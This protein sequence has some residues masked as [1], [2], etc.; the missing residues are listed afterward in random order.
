MSSIDIPSTPAGVATAPVVPQSAAPVQAADVPE[1]KGSSPAGTEAASDSWPISVTDL[2]ALLVQVPNGPEPGEEVSQKAIEGDPDELPAQPSDEDPAPTPPVAA[3]PQP[4]PNPQAPEPGEE[5]GED[6]PKRI[7]VES[8]SEDERLALQIKKAK[9]I[10]LE[11][12]LQ[13]VK[14][15]NPPKAETPPAP[16]ENPFAGIPESVPHSVA[17]IDL[18]LESIDSEQD[19]LEIQIEAR[20]EAF[21][22]ATELKAQR[23]QLRAR[24]KE[25]N[26]AR[27]AVQQAEQSA[28]RAGE[29]REIQTL[30]RAYQDDG[31]QD[32][33]SPLRQA[34]EAV[35]LRWESLGDPRLQAP[36]FLTQLAEA[37][38]VEM[39]RLPHKYAA[40]PPSPAAPSAPAAAS[41]Q[42][43]KIQ[44]LLPASG[45]STTSPPGP[46]P[47][48]DP[49]RLT[50][51]ELSEL[52]GGDLALV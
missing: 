50:R 21:E 12:A 4:T 10:S 8:F 19:A 47:G 41:P 16:L 37:G 3:E 35:R 33:Q 28:A 24:Q 6:L 45:R 29:D 31:I 13:L 32:A 7:R 1:S 15:A 23:Q 49:S 34:M 26:K 2:E 27:F 40:S 48:F 20:L 14:Q 51:H 30:H 9:G 42:T 52:L 25:L 22:D 11:E 36:N 43:P 44:P 38:C 46:A 17:E 18:A 5:E 39:A